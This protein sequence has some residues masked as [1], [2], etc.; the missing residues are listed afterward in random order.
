[1]AHND[2]AALAADTTPSAATPVVVAPSANGNHGKCGR[3]A[4]QA[5]RAPVRAAVD[6][7]VV[8]TRTM[9]ERAAG[10]RSNDRRLSTVPSAWAAPLEVTL[11]RLGVGM[12]P[13]PFPRAGS[14]PGSAL[15]L[16]GRC[17]VSCSWVAGGDSGC[18]AAADAIPN[19]G[20]PHVHERH[21]EQAPESGHS[22][23]PGGP[24]PA[25]DSGS[26][27]ARAG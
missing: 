12:G 22:D 21:A 27:Y 17:P 14:P 24:L 19:P 13:G 25:V 20:A 2:P 9:S 10:T 23:E 11:R 1:M 16:R 4:T 7:R 15:S 26:A 3:V 8:K 6:V 18:G 5:V